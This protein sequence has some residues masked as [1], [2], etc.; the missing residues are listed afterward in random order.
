MTQYRE[1]LRLFS[2]GISKTKIAESV[3]CSRNTVRSILNQ[4]EELGLKWPLSPEI[5]DSQ[6]R[7]KFSGK[8][9]P[10]QGRKYPDFEYI[11]KELLRDG[12]N[13][14]LLWSEYCG[15]CRQ[16]NEIP[17]MYS[18]F[19]EIYRRYEQSKR[20]TMH[21]PRKPGELVE[22]DWAGKTAK[23]FDAETG[24]K[25]NAYV[26]VAALP[27]SQY[28]YVEAFLNMGQES[29]INAH[30][31]MYKYFGG[32]T[33]IIVPDNLKT[34]I[35][36]P[37]LYDPQINKSYRELSEHYRT[38]IIPARIKSPKDKPS[39]ESTVG[40]I[41][42]W[43]I[44]A[45]RNEKFFS[46]AQ[47]NS[48]IR[49]KLERFNSRPFQ[50]REGSRQSVFLA[51]EKD[52]L[53]ELPST[54]YEI[55]TWKQAIVQSNYHIQVD[56]MYYSVP[57]SYIRHKVDVRITIHTIEV[58]HK[59]NRICSHK[60]HTGIRGQYSTHEEHMPEAHKRY[61][62]WDSNKIMEKA[63]NIGPS[64]L[65]TVKSILNSYKV[66]QQAYRSCMGLLKLA[67][68]YSE[69]R[70]ESACEKALSYTPH[71]SLKSVKGILCVW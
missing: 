2:L 42:T 30:I 17:L 36:K 71:T 11:R 41:S 5:T 68:K 15:E 54:P 46:L 59:N 26:F 16:S 32:A 52:L 4:S 65:I 60:K 55:S 37:D 27:Y 8:S 49:E 40:T 24:E 38:A 50:K 28:A 23:I 35:I 18:Q 51:E 43:I 34:G 61:L 33:K 67:E 58:F 63:G 9:G 47:L 20:S 44:A 64:T 19:C 31:N 45:I 53:L 21:I 10:K 57:H 12:V 66:E 39:V 14:K 7:D 29:W 22:V 70:L 69:K 48:V 3:G 62:N 13:L 6:L 1:I 56:K 25:I